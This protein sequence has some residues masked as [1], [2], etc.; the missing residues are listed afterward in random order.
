MALALDPQ[1]GCQWLRPQCAASLTGRFAVDAVLSV[2]RS[3]VCPATHRCACG[4]SCDSRMC[5]RPR[6]VLRRK[7]QRVVAGCQLLPGRMSIALPD[8]AVL[9]LPCLQRR[10]A[11]PLLQVE[12]ALLIAVQLRCRPLLSMLPICSLRC[13]RSDIGFAA[14][15]ASAGSERLL[16]CGGNRRVSL[17]P[18]C[19]CVRRI[20]VSMPMSA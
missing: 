4:C 3:P 10:L 20:P 1:I 15:S 17:R 5:A 6:P 9:P 8:A 16:P 11:Q 18:S 7:I 13:A 14:G 2:R 19:S 12:L